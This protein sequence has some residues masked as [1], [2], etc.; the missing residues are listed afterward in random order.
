MRPS[1]DLSRSLVPFECDATVVAVVELSQ[2]SWLVGGIGVTWDS[3]QR[4]TLSALECFGSE[5][6]GPE[7]PEALAR[8][9]D[10]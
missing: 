9:F 1:N 3:L 10:V 5:S 2:S 6:T 4:C 7:G 8:G